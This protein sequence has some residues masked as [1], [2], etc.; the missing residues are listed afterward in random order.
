MPNSLTRRRGNVP[1]ARAR[2][3]IVLSVLPA[4][5]LTGCVPVADPPSGDRPVLITAT[6]LLEP[7]AIGHQRVYR[8]VHQRPLE[9]DDPASAR[10]VGFELALVV[11]PH[12][13]LF[14]QIVESESQSS[15]PLTRTALPSPADGLD[16]V[17]DLPRLDAADR[18]VLANGGGVYWVL[19]G[20]S[21]EG[22]LTVRAAVVLSASLIGPS[23]RLDVYTREVGGAAIHPAHLELVNNFFYLAVIGDS[24]QWGNGLREGDKISAL[25]ARE[26]EDRLGR[27]VIT[28]RYA[29]AGARILPAEG[30]GI[31]DY[32]CFSEVPR[33]LTSVLTQV[34]QIER[35]D[36]VDLVLLDGCGNDV[37]LDTIT[38]PL[39]D[40]DDLRLITEQYCN[41]AMAALLRKVRRTMPEASVVVTG[42]YLFIS[43]ESNPAGIDTLLSLNQVT[44]S[45]SQN[46]FELR[47][48]MAENSRVFRDVA[49][50][51]LRDAVEYVNG[52]GEA[53]PRIAFVDPGFGP[54]HATF[55]PEARLWGLT[56][57][58]ELLQTLQVNLALAPED[59]LF[60]KRLNVCAGRE[61]AF[62]D[63]ISCL[64][65]SVAH[66]NPAGARAYADAVIDQ[67]AEL[68]VLPPG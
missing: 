64:Y 18:A 37:G 66:P 32:N 14:L 27:R 51:S 36:L 57:D 41:G 62:F 52:E 60:E 17:R 42:Y 46:V 40:P 20:G 23:C 28:Q 38:F 24:I 63:L 15:T 2:R 25:V 67:L 68:G 48:A 6:R 16:L 31:C 47:D 65:V 35:P 33:T 26:I 44:S 4:A 5:V 10:V 1:V 29:V 58:L 53:P 34:D 12:A 7:P 54:A 13:A 50:A 8:P 19:P 43:D 39:T 49:N 9:G 11:D 61:L 21:E 30:D 45:S 56:D 55:A 22:P 3:R 59:P